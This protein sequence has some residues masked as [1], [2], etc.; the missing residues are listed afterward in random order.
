MRR[1]VITKGR[2]LFLKAA[3]MP[4]V[5]VTLW[6]TRGEALLQDRRLARA[7]QSEASTGEAATG[8]A[9]FDTRDPRH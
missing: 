3:A 4:A 2:I 8:D 7:L 1:K 6:A 9:T 5:D